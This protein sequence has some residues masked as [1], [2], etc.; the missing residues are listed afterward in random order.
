MEELRIENIKGCLKCAGKVCEGVD[1]R[2]SWNKGISELLES[3]TACYIH[4]SS[5][6]FQA[7][8]SSANG[9]VNTCDWWEQMKDFQHMIQCQA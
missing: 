8:I 2:E 3:F 9:R 5:S 1:F 4:G 7:S 6:P